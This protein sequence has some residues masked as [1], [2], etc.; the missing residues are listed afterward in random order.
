MKKIFIERQNRLLKIA[1]KYGDSLKECF[2]EEETDSPKVGDIYRGVVKNIVTSIKGAFIDVG[3]SKNCYLSLTEANYENTLKKGD[4]VMVEIIK[5]EIGKKGPKV[6]RSISL[7]GA[8]AVLTK[9][10]N[11]LEIS[12][13]I[14]NKDFKEL[15]ESSISKPEN[16][17]IVIRTKAENIDISILREEIE[18]LIH[19]YKDICNKFTYSSKVGPLYKDKG[20]LSRILRNYTEDGAQIFVDNYDDYFYYENLIKGKQLKNVHINFYEG[21]LSIFDNYGIEK[22]ILALRHNKINLSSGGNIVLER[23]EAMNV[24][25]VNTAKNIKNSLKDS[26]I[27]VT[28]KEAAKEIVKQIR[29]RNLGGIIVIDFVDMKS[30]EDKAV[31]LKVLQ[32][33]FKDDKHNTKIYPFTELNLIQITRKKYGKSICDYV[34]NSCEHCKGT[35]E[36]VSLKYLLS[37]LRGKVNKIKLDQEIKNIYMELDKNYESEIKSDIITF[38]EELNALDCDIFIRFQE[39]LDNFKVEPLIFHSQ[40]EDMRE[41]QVFSAKLKYVKN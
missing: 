38:A 1:V 6:T 3:Y 20:I 40:I 37:I 13:K 26:S 16:I 33:E 4:E 41:L 19:R 18:E 11:K 2:I 31:V 34:F 25:D 5:E 21:P 39:S 7:P 8:Y 22:E 9:E 27:V 10:H 35:G 17:G 14:K 30:D 24:V 28:N 32:E 36:K 15:V 23:T 12:S 29:L